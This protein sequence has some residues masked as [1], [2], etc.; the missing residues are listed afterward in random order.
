MSDFLTELRSELLD[1][2]AAR[3]RSGR[4]RR[5]LRALESDAPRALVAV[6]AVAAL[7][8]AVFVMRAMAPPPSASPRVV[9]VIRVGGNATDAALAD[10]SVWISDFTGQRVVRLLPANRRVVGRIA[11]GGPPV[12]VTAGRNGTWTRTAVGEGGMVTRVG[13]DR[14]TPVGNG[15]TL[16]A[17]ATAIW[18]ADVELQPEGIHR[19]DARTGRNADFVDIPGVHALATGGDALWAV[20][21]NGTVLRLDGRTGAMRARWPAIALSAGTAGPALVADADGA[22]VLQLAQGADNQ[23]IR[24]EGDRV[25]RRLPLPQSV[26][27]LLAQAPDGLWTVSED[28][29]QHRYAALRLNAQNG[30]VTARVDLGIRNPTALLPVGDEV[31]ATASDGTVTV[32]GDQ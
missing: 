26:I 8:V 32:I 11:V 2:H 4:T 25:A 30:K 15:S 23:A 28:A 5:I 31:W 9:D 6:T 17:G 21:G 7:V 16:A 10:G 13:S 12:A 29:V 14:A 24:F 27:P 1:A 20:T 3:R 22:W 19:I 18:A